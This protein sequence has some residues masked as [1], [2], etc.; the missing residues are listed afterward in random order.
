MYYKMKKSEKLF[1]FTKFNIDFDIIFLYD[2]SY[3]SCIGGIQCFS[4]YS[5]IT[6]RKI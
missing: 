4:Y 1:E 6:I 2:N 5:Y 3:V